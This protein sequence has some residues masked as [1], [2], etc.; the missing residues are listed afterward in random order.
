MD[1]EK[2]FFDGLEDEIRL[3][4]VGKSSHRDIGSQHIS[5]KYIHGRV[6]YSAKRF[7]ETAAASNDVA[8]ENE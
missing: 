2:K 8:A 3:T 5:V 6:P 4:T 7:F 1:K